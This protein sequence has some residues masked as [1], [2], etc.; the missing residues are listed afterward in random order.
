MVPGSKKKHEGIIHPT[1]KGGP[2]FTLPEKTHEIL[3]D[4]GDFLGD[5]LVYIQLG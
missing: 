5:A 4:P 2:K 1:K 3:F